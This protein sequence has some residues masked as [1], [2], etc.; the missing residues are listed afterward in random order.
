MGALG[1]VLIHLS[2]VPSS[3]AP[4]VPLV[5]ALTGGAAAAI[6]YIRREHS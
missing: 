5:M 4:A 3:I 2:P 6:T 1:F